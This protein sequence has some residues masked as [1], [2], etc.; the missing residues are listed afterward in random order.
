MRAAVPASVHVRVA[1]VTAIITFA[2][3]PVRGVAQ[4]GADARVSSG[5]RNDAH[6]TAPVAHATRFDDAIAL[7]GRLDEAAWAAA[8]PITEFYQTDPVDGAPATE[9]TE[10][11]IIYD[12]LAIY[13]GARMWES[14]GEVRKRL[15]RRDSFLMDSDWFYVMFDSYHDHQRAYQFSVNPAGV[16]R[17]EITGGGGGGPRG[18]ASWDAVWDVVTSVDDEGWTVEIRIPFSQLRFSRADRQTWGVQFGRRAISKEESTIFAFTPKS[19][20]GGV[21]RYGHLEGL[22]GIQPG[23]KLELLPYSVARAEYVGVDSG[24]PFRD[25]SDWFGGAGLDL[26]Y[27]VTSSMT[28]DATFNPDFGQVEVDPAV[29]NLSAFETSFDEKRPFF[30]EGADIFRFNELRLFYSRRIG[31][32]PQ[33]SLPSGTEFAHRP[34]NS[35][36]LTAAK[37]TGQT[38]SGWNIGIV[39][40]VTAEEHA[41][42]VDGEAAFDE[43]VVEPMTNYLVARAE[44]NLRQGQ[45]TVGVIGTAVNRRLNGDA[46]LAGLLR[47]SAWAGGVDFSHQFLERTWEVAGYFAYS[48]VNGSADA[49]LRTQLASSRYYQRPDADYVDVDSALTSLDGYAARLQLN[50]VA[51]LHWRGEANVSAVS[52]GFEVNDAG[53]QTAADRLGADVN[54]T[55]VENRVGRV[56]RNYRISV[57]NSS[58]WNYGMERLAARTTLSVNGQ[59]ANYWGGNFNVTRQFEGYDDRLTRGGPLALD[60]AGNN[61]DVRFNTDFRSKVSFNLESRYSWGE[62]GGWNGMGSVRMTYRPAENWSVTLGPR[63][64][65]SFTNAQYLFSV[66]DEEAAGTFGRRYVF[67]PINQTTLSMETRVNLTFTPDLSLEVYTQPFVS[68]GEYGDPRQLRAPGTYAF[69]PWDETISSRDFSTTS[70]RGNAVLRWE[71]RPGSTV[72]LVWQQQ[73][74]G[75]TGSGLFDFGRDT[76][77]IF[78]AHPDNVFLVKLNYWLNF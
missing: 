2:L 73:R 78:N 35:T 24:D 28:L 3:N 30:V 7:D 4:D 31:R 11:H 19:Q 21:A 39:E 57:R 20:R 64:N 46:T 10:V 29:V 49:L 8:V 17:D 37:L 47:S 51:G 76:R 40:A 5:T 58:D 74:R 9:R 12:D 43:T 13:I 72:F 48:R 53:F 14:T 55:Y 77:A 6:D 66:E 18:D 41:T 54:L 1:A 56:F 61:I 22:E 65:R 69:D 63:Y 33:G 44:K 36:I 26:K 32:A 71:W 15:G 23:R 50:K 38:A 34:D 75:S 42:T 27:R 62:S 45:S 25:G 68:T 60:P 59:F 70:L 67:A 16:K 52:P